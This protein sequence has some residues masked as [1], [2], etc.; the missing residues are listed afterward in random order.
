[1]KYSN[2]CRQYFWL[3]NVIVFFQRTLSFFIT[4]ITK[5]RTICSFN[6]WINKTTRS[7]SYK[8]LIGCDPFHSLFLLLTISLKQLFKSALQN[9]SK[10]IRKDLWRSSSS[11]ITRCNLSRK[12][13]IK[14]KF[15]RTILSRTTFGEFFASG[16]GFAQPYQNKSIYF[17]SLMNKYLTG[18]IRDI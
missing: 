2:L 9:F 6:D 12:D 15:F 5:W 8:L 11:K 4:K 1:M 10:V 3:Y 16:V 17:G 7:N 13:F 18:V 14:V